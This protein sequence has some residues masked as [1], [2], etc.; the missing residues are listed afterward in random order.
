MKAFAAAFLLATSLPNS[1]Q[2]ELIT[3]GDSLTFAYEAEFGFQISIPFG[4]T[5]GDGFD[6]EEVKNWAEI[7]HQE[8]S[9]DF[10]LGARQTL[11][12]DFSFFSYDLYFRQDHNWA[13]PGLKINQLRR[14]L[15]N[16][17]TLLELIAEDEDF[18]AF[19]DILATTDFEFE[20]TEME[21]QIANSEGRLVFFIG[22]NDADSI[23][24]LVYEG[25]PPAD[26]IS[27][28]LADSAAILDRVQELNPDLPIVLVNLPHVGITPL[29]KEAH[30]TDEVKTGRATAFF[31]ELN[32][33]LAELAQ[34]RGIGY[35]DIF[36]ATLPLLGEQALS[37]YGVPFAN[38]GSAEGDLNFVW[39]DGPFSMNFHPNTSAQILI[40][41]EI[42]GAFNEKYGT[43]LRPLG[44]EEALTTLLRRDPSAVDMDFPTWAISYSLPE[45][46]QDDDSDGDGLT[47]GLEF[48]L[49][50]NPQLSDSEKITSTQV[51]VEGNSFLEIAYP[52]RYPASSHVTLMP[53]STADLAT[54]FSD[55]VTLPAEGSDGLFRARLPLERT[56][57]F[58]RLEARPQE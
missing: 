5:Y 51:E 20:L 11:T 36:S 9:P 56:R 15:D 19:A 44:A 13:V 55:F 42:V 45:L 43:A 40:A 10:D 16:E 34:S 31:G 25:N 21:Q 32:R 50:L 26:F 3:L 38:A 23:Y 8:R 1:A 54:G 39:L 48:A 49:G 12:A 47:A 29:I 22:G 35:A 14:F 6:P 58:L 57:G 33:Q 28:Y 7:L 18:A 52:L 53:Q 4:E 30:P 37:V 2:T 27:D 46:S 24:H 41:N 17:A